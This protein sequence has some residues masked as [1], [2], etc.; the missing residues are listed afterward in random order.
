MVAVTGCQT[1]S[2]EPIAELPTTTVPA[3][4]LEVDVEVDV[5]EVTALLDQAEAAMQRDHLTYPA[6][7]SALGLFDTVLAIDPDNAEAQR[8]LERIVEYYLGMAEEAAQHNQLARARSML[9]RARIVDADHPAFEP[10]EI[11]IRLLANA[12]RN[13][14]ILD[15][16]QLKNRSGALSQPL[17][18]LGSRARTAN[19]RAV[20]RVRNDS[21]GRWVYQQMNLA[22]GDA[23]IRAQIQIG[24]PPVVDLLCFSE[25]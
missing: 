13:R 10:I 12:R 16:D 15:R 17:K 20:I 8:G 24:S 19:C 2:A 5:E 1:R 3:Q 21:E 9:D 22:P 4:P 6:Q 18:N 14:L 11:Q 25:G 7:G 23:R